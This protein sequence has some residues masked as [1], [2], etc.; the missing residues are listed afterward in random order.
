MRKLE[1]ELSYYKVLINSQ[2]GTNTSTTML[3]K[4]YQLRRKII[5]VKNRKNKIKKIFNI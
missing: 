2:Y 4:A 3:D 5:T 1:S